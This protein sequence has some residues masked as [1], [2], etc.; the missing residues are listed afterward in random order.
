M[1]CGPVKTSFLIMGY[2]NTWNMIST[3]E[4]SNILCNIW[5]YR[6]FWNKR[7]RLQFYR[8]ILISSWK[9]H[10]W[11]VNP[12]MHYI[13]PDF[14]GHSIDLQINGTLVSIEA[15]SK[16]G[17]LHN[18][19]KSFHLRMFSHTPTVPFHLRL[20]PTPSRKVIVNASF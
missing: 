18:S 11:N 19:R 1:C 14:L 10:V 12:C 16:L 7:E 2:V 3:S 8:M 5:F 17:K 15:T 9:D 4:S 20:P 6:V 13:V